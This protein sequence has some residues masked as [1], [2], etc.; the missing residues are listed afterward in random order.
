MKPSELF[1]FK[2]TK[3]VA[4]LLFFLVAS[5]KKFQRAMR[6]HTH[7]PQMQMQIRRDEHGTHK[8]AH[9]SWILCSVSR[10]RSKTICILCSPLRYKCCL[11]LLY[12]TSIR[13]F[14]CSWDNRALIY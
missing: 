3:N 9:G 13:D 5:N 2:D 11:T 8:H 4:A 1:C 7:M 6:S 12:V 14:F 10:V